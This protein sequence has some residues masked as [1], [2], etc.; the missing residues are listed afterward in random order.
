MK[1][2]LAIIGLVGVVALLSSCKT[3]AP[4]DP[5]GSTPAEERECLAAGGHATRGLV[6][7]ICS[8]PTGDGGKACNNFYDC[9]GQCL[10]DGRVCSSVTPMLGCFSTYEDGE[11]VEI[12]VD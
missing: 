11:T 9:E 1:Q 7:L 6:G 4:G 10:A 5:A 3:Q 2:I 8:M 12:C